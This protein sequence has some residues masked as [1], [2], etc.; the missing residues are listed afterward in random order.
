MAA[1]FL[2][3][4]RHFLFAEGRRG[5]NILSRNRSRLVYVSYTAIQ[6]QNLTVS[7]SYDFVQYTWHGVLYRFPLNQRQPDK[8]NLK[9]FNGTVELNFKPITDLLSMT[10]EPDT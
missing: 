9:L 10:S 3:F 4:L 5:S 7:A 2:L 1:V 8:Q 6:L